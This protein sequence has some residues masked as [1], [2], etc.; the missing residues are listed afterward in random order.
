MPQF[1]EQT[2]ESWSSL[3]EATTRTTWQIFLEKQPRTETL[4]TINSFQKNR[5]NAFLIYSPL[6]QM[7][8]KFKLLTYS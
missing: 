2:V 5:H 8:Q 3:E 1:L 6:F 4:R 7:F